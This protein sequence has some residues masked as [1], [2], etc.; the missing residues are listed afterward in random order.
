[1][2]FLDLD[3]NLR[4]VCL[5]FD[6]QVP[7]RLLNSERV[8]L[9]VDNDEGEFISVT[10]GADWAALDMGDRLVPRTTPERFIYLL[11][12]NPA[13]AQVGFIEDNNFLCGEPIRFA[14]GLLSRL[15]DP[16][17][18]YTSYVSL[19]RKAA[20]LAIFTQTFNEGEMLLYW[21]AYYAKLV[22]HENLYVLNNGST[23][24]SCD[25]LHPKTNL[26]NL[27]TV[28][29]DHEHFA[30][31]Q[32]YFQRFLL[33]RY[34][35]VL[36]VDTDEFVVCQGDMVEMLQTLPKGTYRPEHA[37][38][39]LHNWETEPEFDFSAP[40]FAQRKHSI[41]GTNLLL[42][43]I[44]S[45]IATTWSAGNHMA[46]EIHTALPELYVVHLKYF[47][48][49]FLYR[50]NDKWSQMIQTE[51]EV[52]ICKQISVLSALGGEKM[53]E[54]SA[55]EIADRLAEPALPLPAWLTAKL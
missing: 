25:K 36:K 45:S 2:A 31:Q 34:D 41:K 18:L 30:Q 39:V 23:D 9:L 48:M 15:Y 7:A 3:T 22:G 10:V 24:G 55:Q 26:I 11:M 5:L 12:H 17:K 47:D 1:M 51:N 13:K 37:V 29:V 16:L 46:A 32:S 8:T 42:R 27:P 49:R 33:M 35:W 38:E 50:K 53:G 19:E 52:G 44:L 54:Y 28:P 21:E 43:P 40:V 4:R 6:Q 20:P 14:S